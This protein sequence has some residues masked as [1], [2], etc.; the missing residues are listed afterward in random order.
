MKDFIISGTDKDTTH[1]WSFAEKQ[2]DQNE[3]KIVFTEVSRVDKKE[4]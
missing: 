1:F 4:I 2:D 3:T